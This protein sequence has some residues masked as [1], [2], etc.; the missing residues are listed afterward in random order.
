MRQDNVFSRVC[1]S[2]SLSVHRDVPNV[3]GPGPGP[4]SVQGPNPSPSPPRNVQTWTSLYREPLPLVTMKHEL[5]ESGWLA[6]GWIAFLLRWRS[7][8]EQNS[9]AGPGGAGDAHPP[10]RPNSLIFVHFSAKIV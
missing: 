3:Q 2:L 10:L 5:S 6:L 1:L 4:T 9:M 8:A 7:L